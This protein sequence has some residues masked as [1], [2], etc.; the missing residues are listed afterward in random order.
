M[1]FIMK[2][3]TNNRLL[4][5]LGC[6]LLALMVSLLYINISQFSGEVYWRNIGK[7]LYKLD[8]SW[9]KFP[10]KFTGQVFG[11]A[12]NDV[13]GLIYVA[14]RGDNIPKVL[15]F[16][17]DGYFVNAWNTSTIEMP[18]GIFVANASTEPSIWI[19]DVGQGPYGHTIK[20]Y[21]TSGKLIRILG[22][23]GEAGSSVTPLQF[24]QPAEIFVH[25][26]GDIYIVDGDG[27]LN[28]RL[29]KLSKDFEVIW[30]HGGKGIGQG[31]FNIPHS[32]AVDKY[33]RVWVADRENKRI[34]VFSAISGEWLGSWSSCFFEDGPYSVRFT[35]D[36]KYIIIARL[37]INEI[38]LLKAPPVGEIGLCNII[39]S[40]KMA[41]G[42]KPHLVDIDINTQ[43]FYVAEIGA[44]QAQKFVP[45]FWGFIFDIFI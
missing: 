4:V 14:Q 10:E 24:D 28:N 9:P 19:T 20:Q 41:D 45:Y 31:Q 38:M 43:D 16:N 21:T 6:I 18:H 33:D 26:S 25:S 13:T 39:S 34:Q 35:S 12:V 36:Q 1:R 27:G 40:I 2:K 44:Q 30:M 5:A 8:V 7:N 37:N 29:I 3:K 17:R 15:V 22:S 32:V 42:I 11:V 23:P